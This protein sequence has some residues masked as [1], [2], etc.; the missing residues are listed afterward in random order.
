[1]RIILARTPGPRTAAAVT[2]RA[3]RARPGTP[4]APGGWTRL[5]RVTVNARHGEMVTA[6]WIAYDRRGRRRRRYAYYITGQVAGDLAAYLDHARS[7]NAALQLVATAHA[8]WMHEQSK[9]QGM[10]GKQL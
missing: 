6:G 2:Y 8:A 3:G 10:Q 1:M 9:W 4:G 5:W 7:P